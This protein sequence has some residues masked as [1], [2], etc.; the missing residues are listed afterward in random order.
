MTILQEEQG[1]QEKARES[2]DQDIKLESRRRERRERSEK[3]RKKE[4]IE[5][6]GSRR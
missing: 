1:L 5:K 3:D 6:V 4:M 2:G